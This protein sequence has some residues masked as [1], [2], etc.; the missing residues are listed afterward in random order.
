MLE[1]KHLTKTFDGFRA[2]DDL[3]LTVPR[4]AVYGLVG[5]NG[6][7]KSTLIRCLMGIY[8]TDAG[9]I[10]LDAQPIYECVG[11]KQRM[12][13][14]PDEVFFEGGDSIRDLKQ[15]YAAAY[16]GFDSA[17]FDRLGAVFGLNQRQPIRRFSKGMQKQAAFWLA[18]S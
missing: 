1:V 14:I 11:K 13:Y 9:E 6:A 3:S 16:P 2:L 15:L 7:G 18:I 17:R 12:V 10:T 5:P 4:G 8:R